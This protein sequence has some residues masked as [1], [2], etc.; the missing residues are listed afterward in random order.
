M[1]N[2]SPLEEIFFAA[3]EM[4]SAEKR[5]AYLEEACAGEAIQAGTR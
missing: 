3:L 5:T 2:P 4:G 1:S